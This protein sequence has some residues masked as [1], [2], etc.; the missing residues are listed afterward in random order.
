MS[1]AVFQL[2][3]PSTS[4]TTNFSF[5]SRHDASK[6]RIKYSSPTTFKENISTL[7]SSCAMIIKK[8]CQQIFYLIQDRT[9][10]STLFTL[11]SNRNKSEEWN[12]SDTF[13]KKRKRSIGKTLDDEFMEEKGR[14]WR[15]I[16]SSFDVENGR[17][18]VAGNNGIN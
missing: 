5:F 8:A 16:E 7:L 14:G 3:S 15:E 4:D 11:G 17:M 9:C 1:V 18:R 2:G 13:F 6:N 10:V 12:E